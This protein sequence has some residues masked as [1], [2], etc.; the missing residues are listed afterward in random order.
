MNAS[1]T[2]ATGDVIEFQLFDTE[3]TALVLLAAEEN[4]ILDLCDGSVPVVLQ[5]SELGH[6]RR[7]EPELLGIAA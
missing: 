6:V 3:V 7:F 1:S 4:V 5:R 2:I